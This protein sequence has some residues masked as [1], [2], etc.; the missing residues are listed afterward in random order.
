M[1]RVLS[2]SYSSVL[3][4]RAKCMRQ[5]RNLPRWMG[6][7]RN[8]AYS[9]PITCPIL[10]F[11]APKISPEKLK[12][13]ST[14]PASPASS[15]SSCPPA[16]PS[17]AFTSS[18]SSNFSNSRVNLS[19]SPK[20]TFLKHFA[21]KVCQHLHATCIH[22]RKCWRRGVVVSVVRCVNEVTLSSTR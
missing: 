3:A 21:F 10:L 12:L 15:P 9:I 4:R 18:W 16:A 20:I 5:S 17:S 13:D 7:D 22:E 8:G 11:H 19:S 6:M 1:F 14:V 2:S